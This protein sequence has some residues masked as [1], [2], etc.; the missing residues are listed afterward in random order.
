MISGAEAD[1][2]EKQNEEILKNK[3]TVRSPAEHHEK[4]GPV[5]SP[6]SHNILPLGRG[7]PQAK[8]HLFSVYTY[9][10]KYLISQ[11]SFSQIWEENGKVFEAK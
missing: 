6:S 9:C 4:S 3:C 7:Y 10:I 5:P 11:K 2:K 1:P 8:S